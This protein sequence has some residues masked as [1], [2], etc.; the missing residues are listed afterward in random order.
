MFGGGDS[1]CSPVE[2]CHTCPGDCTCTPLCRD[3][4]CDPPETAT[5][6]PGDC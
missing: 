4:Y 2:N 3:G 5:S 1:A 6:C